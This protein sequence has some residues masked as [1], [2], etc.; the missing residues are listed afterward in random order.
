M[1]L[2]ATEIVGALILQPQVFEDD[3]GYFFESFNAKRFLDATAVTATFVQDN[4]SGSRRNVLRGLHYQLRN[5]QGKLVRCVAGRVFDVVVDLRPASATF[6]RWISHELCSE[7][8]EQLWIPPGC[9]HGFLTLSEFADVLY[10]TT[11]YWLSTDE[12]CIRWDDPQL[13]ISWPI[14]GVPTLSEKDRCGTT[15]S[16][17]IRELTE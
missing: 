7:Q 13:A 17:A 9:A 14:D 5:P 16:D 12:R 1:K 15:W 10:K 4:H 2:I 11:D 8:H 3:R 6:G